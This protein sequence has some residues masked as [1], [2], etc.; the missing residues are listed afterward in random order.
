VPL[1]GHFHH[2]AVAHVSTALVG[3]TPSDQGRSYSM[4]MDGMLTYHHVVSV[5]P[6]ASKPCKHVNIGVSLLASACTNKLSSTPISELWNCSY[7]MERRV[8]GR[9]V[10][11]RNFVAASSERDLVRWGIFSNS[12]MDPFLKY[13]LP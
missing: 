6:K 11:V 3:T 9:Y 13:T 12:G 5:K 2:V 8:A 4:K 10:G 7:S 1:G